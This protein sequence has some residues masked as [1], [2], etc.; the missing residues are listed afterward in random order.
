MEFRL[1]A[2]IYFSSKKRKYINLPKNI[3]Y[4]KALL[5]LYYVYRLKIFLYY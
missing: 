5:Y 3:L 1:N 4:K 2:K